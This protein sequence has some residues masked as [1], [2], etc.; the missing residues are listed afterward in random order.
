MS[1][2]GPFVAAKAIA[3]AASVAEYWKELGRPRW[4]EHKKYEMELMARYPDAPT[5]ERCSDCDG[6][7][8][9]GRNGGCDACGGKCF[10]LAIIDP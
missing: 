5:I 9:I 8:R 2:Y 3:G 7:G 6:S 4:I 1:E 10:V